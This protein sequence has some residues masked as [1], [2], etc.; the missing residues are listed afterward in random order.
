MFKELA[1]LLRQRAA[2]FTVTVSAPKGRSDRLRK[3]TPGGT[4]K[5][6]RNTATSV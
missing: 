5:M 4:M 2:L 3:A 6:S 1:P